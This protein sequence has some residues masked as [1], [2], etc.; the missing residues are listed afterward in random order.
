MK[1]H[2]NHIINQNVISSSTS[3][4]FEYV[5]QCFEPYRDVKLCC[6]IGMARWFHLRSESEISTGSRWTFRLLPILWGSVIRL[7]IRGK[8][9]VDLLQ[10]LC[11][12]SSYSVGDSVARIESNTRE[13][14]APDG[15]FIT[16]TG[17]FLRSHRVCHYP[18]STAVGSNSSADSSVFAFLQYIMALATAWSWGFITHCKKKVE[19]T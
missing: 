17:I 12:Y 5:V 15:D 3:L 18:Q 8:P 13:V 9:V 2:S 11:F 1:I 16:V 6:T 7:V 4:I 10:V 14:K 19:L